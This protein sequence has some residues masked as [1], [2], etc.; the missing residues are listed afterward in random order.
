MVHS[1]LV[2]HFVKFLRVPS[3]RIPLNEILQFHPDLTRIRNCEPGPLDVIAAADD[4]CCTLWSAR[5]GI[6][7]IKAMHKRFNRDFLAV[8]AVVSASA[9]V[10]VSGADAQDEEDFFHLGVVEYEIAC[11]PCHGTDG[12]GDG[13]DAQFLET[14]PTDLTG[15]AQ[16]NGGEFPAD[17]LRQ[18]VDGR[19]WVA[20][21]GPRAMPVWGERYRSL[22]SDAGIADAEQE[23]QTRIDALVDYVESLQEP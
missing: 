6:K 14:R 9:I 2:F 11:L 17:R 4:I 12:R 16:A 22:A 3:M 10:G 7:S 1:L 15:I 23:V 8:I 19:T 20:D 18:I 13:P 5:S 21:H